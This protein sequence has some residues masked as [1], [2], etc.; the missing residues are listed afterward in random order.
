MI[1]LFMYAASISYLTVEYAFVDVF[2][3]TVTNYNGQE[4]NGGLVS[5]WLNI[6]NFNTKTGLI[7]TGAYTPINATYYDRVETFTTAAAAVAWNL[8]GLLT[9]MAILNLVLFLGVPP[10][11][12]A[13]IGVLYTLLLART[14]IALIRGV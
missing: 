4:L 5:T 13:G 11:F 12:V 3:L 14:I 2:H 10:I 1:I 9:G 7:V 8:I 6:D